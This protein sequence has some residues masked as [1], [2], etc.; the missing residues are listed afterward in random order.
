MIANSL[1][2]ARALTLPT[3][4][5]MLARSPSVQYFWDNNKELLE[6][7][8]S[9][10]ESNET[11]SELINEDIISSALKEAVNK[12]WA[13]PDDESAVK[14][15]WQEVSPGVYQC[16]FFD[17]E[18]LADLRQYLAAASEA[19]IPLRPPYGLVLNRNGAMLDPRSEGYLAAPQFQSWY[20][21][22]MNKYMR[23]IARMLFPE[24]TGADSQ[25]FGFSIQYHPKKDTSLRLHTDASAATLNINMNL[26]N[27]EFTGSEVDFFD[28]NTGKTNRT[29]FKPG[30]A[31][32]HRGN[33]AHAAQPITSGERSNLVFWLYGERGFVPTSPTVPNGVNSAKRWSETTTPADRFAPF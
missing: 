32:L 2:Q 16:Q 20:Q 11:L 25:T 30:V 3:R 12:A 23:P 15:L 14:E 5:E 10:W 29:S 17:P 33:V 18:K 21:Q 9:D 8:W 28:P 31:M 19:K 4:E 1:Q 13:N 6:S 27:E 24:I 26:P 7:A 22:I